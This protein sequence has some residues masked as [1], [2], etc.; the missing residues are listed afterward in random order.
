M[1]LLY[2]II[3][4]VIVGKNGSRIKNVAKLLYN[5]PSETIYVIHKNE[6]FPQM[7]ISDKV[8]HIDTIISST[9]YIHKWSI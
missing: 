6:K 3:V 1:I 7:D 9:K 8:D 2:P 5:N 4:L